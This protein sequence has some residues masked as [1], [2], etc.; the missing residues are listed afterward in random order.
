MA[1]LE[2]LKEEDLANKALVLGE[3]FRKALVA[4]NSPLIETG[5]I[6]PLILQLNLINFLITVR[7]KGLLNAIVISKKATRTAWQ[8]C[9]LMKQKGLL[10]KPTHENIIRL[11]PPLCITEEELQKGVRIIQEA[12]NEVEKIDP[13]VFK[14]WDLQMNKILILSEQKN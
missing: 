10:A 1:A 2:V 9:L 3:K 12:L 7:G 5:K 6:I 11:A 14:E 8:I 13:E 4:M